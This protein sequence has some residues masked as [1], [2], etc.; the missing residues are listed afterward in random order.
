MSYNKGQC[1]VDWILSAQPYKPPVELWIT[2]AIL[3]GLIVLLGA[4]VMLYRRKMLSDPDSSS[5]SDAWSL[6]DLARLRSQGDIT[7][8][9]YQA[10]RAAI[11]QTFTGQRPSDSETRLPEVPPEALPSGSV[12]AG[13]ESDDGEEWD[14]VAEGLEN[15]GERRKT[16]T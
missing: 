13:R 11:I 4:G 16:D 9:E 14:W 6:D 1:H 5:K 3:V 2:C 8:A 10:M 12:S 15:E 7:E